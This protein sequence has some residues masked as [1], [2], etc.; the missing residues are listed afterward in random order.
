MRLDRVQ[1]GEDVGVIIFQVIHDGRLRVVMHELA[2]L[3]EEGR[4]VFIGF[5][6][7]EVR[8][9]A[10]AVDLAAETGGNAK[11]HRYATDQEARRIA[12]VFE[13]PGQHGRGGRLAMR[14]GHGQYPLVAQD[15]FA[16]PLRAGHIRQAAVE[17]F[18]HQRVTARDDI[19]NHIQ[20]RVQLGLFGIKALDQ[21]DSLRFQLGA[22]RRI[23]VGIATGD[24]MAG[25]LGQHGQAA[26]EG[27]ANAEN[28]NM[29]VISAKGARLSK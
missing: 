4:V 29:H 3:V 11:V 10:L 5:D 19:A 27:T 8:I 6:D 21:F 14:A 2:A 17:D 13:Y 22:H 9:G 28:M 26:H 20:I 7:E 15:V 23:H 16:D 24:F 18:F 1:I 12:R 25:F